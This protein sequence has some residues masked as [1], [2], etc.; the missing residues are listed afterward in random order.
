[1]SDSKVNWPD[2]ASPL[3]FHPDHVHEIG[4]ITVEITSLEMMLGDLLGALLNLEDEV[5]HDIYFTPRVAIA[6]LDV[7]INVVGTTQFNA[8][9]ELRGA[10]KKVVTRAK[11]LIG[12]RH[13]LI[14]AHWTISFDGTAVGRLRL[15]SDADFIPDTVTLRSLK[16]LVE[17]IRALVKEVRHVIDRA[18]EALRPEMWPQI[19]AALEANAEDLRQD[20]LRQ[21]A[22]FEARAARPKAS[23]P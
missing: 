15:P 4:M 17:D 23:P 21:E 9:S 16:K 10:V 14:H 7:L 1:M 5:S 13:D 22:L 20:N 8:H 2:L 12:Q 3:R 18:Y 11:A 6:R 19:H